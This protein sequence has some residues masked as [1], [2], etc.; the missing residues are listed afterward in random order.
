MSQASEVYARLLLPKKLGLPLWTPEPDDNLSDEYRKKGVS[1]G[2]VGIMKS[3]GDFDFLFNICV[4]SD[5]PV[6]HRGVPPG[7]E[8][9]SKLTP[10]IE[11][12]RRDE[13]HS[14]NTAIASSSM[15]KKDISANISIQDNPYA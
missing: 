2:D 1:I 8:D 13:F 14:P 5:D 3:D 10:P 12:S 7:F 15:I 9:M 11:I 4:S 6:N